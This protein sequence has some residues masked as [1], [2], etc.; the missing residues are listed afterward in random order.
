MQR[1]RTELEGRYY[2]LAPRRN[3]LL[4]VLAIIA[5]LILIAAIVAIYA[6]LP[7][8]PL[9]RAERVTQTTDAHIVRVFP[10][11]RRGN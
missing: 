8:E 10:I 7:I 1:Y 9:K 2:K 4:P 6:I 3:E 5:S 11:P